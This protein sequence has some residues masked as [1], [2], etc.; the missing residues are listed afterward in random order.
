MSRFDLRSYRWEINLNSSAAPLLRMRRVT[1]FVD[2]QFQRLQL[3]P[4]FCPIS[5]SD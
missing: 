2:G 3:L 1:A 5:G 4:H